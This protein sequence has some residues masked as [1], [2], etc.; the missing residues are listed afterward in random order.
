MRRLTMPGMSLFAKLNQ[1]KEKGRPRFVKVLEDGF[2]KPETVLGGATEDEVAY[3]DR[4]V[5]ALNPE[6]GTWTVLKNSEITNYE[7]RIKILS[8]K[9]EDGKLVP[10][11]I[12]PAGKKEML[13][14]EFRRGKNL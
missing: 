8:A 9:I 2:I 10:I 12:V 11:R 14:E 3:A 1:K 6:P 13:W 5:R 4:Q 7:L